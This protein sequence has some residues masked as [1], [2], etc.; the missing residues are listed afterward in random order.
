MEQS[1]TLQWGDDERDSVGIQRGMGG[2]A[3]QHADSKPQSPPAPGLH[4]GVLTQRSVS[5]MLR[6]WMNLLPASS[7]SLSLISG[8]REGEM[9]SARLLQTRPLLGVELSLH[10]LRY[11]CG[12]NPSRHCL[13]DRRPPAVLYETRELTVFPFP[14]NRFLCS[15]I[16]RGRYRDTISGSVYILRILFPSS[17]DAEHSNLH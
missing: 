10:C 9:T 4:P 2:G 16:F 17:R 1:Q 13:P 8:A 5:R 15:W 3:L 7:A 12:L 11:L 6:S 14:P